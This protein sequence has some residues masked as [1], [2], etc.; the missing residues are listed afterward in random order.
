[1]RIL[2]DDIYKSILQSARKEFISKGFKE[3]SMRS[4]AK[5]AGVG[6]SNIYNYFKSKD[7]IFL[8]IV[9][10]AQKD[11]FGFITHQHTE[12]GVDFSNI[13]AMEHNEEAIEYFIDLIFKYE[14]EY[15][16]LL[17][18]SEGSSMSNFRDNLTDHMTQI[19][20]TYMELVKKYYP[21][22]NTISDFFFHAL[23]SWMTSILGEIV[24]HKVN[25]K[26]IRDFFDEYFR[27]GFAGWREL[28]GI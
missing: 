9:I 12:E 13:S 28:S 6:L 18:Q 27:Y 19:S 23:A 7:E 25:R 22:A 14:E 21:K 1:M 5:D 8:T 24:T 2:K 26:K 15:R 16:L 10:P 3:A 4:I 20:Y 17:Y 11:L